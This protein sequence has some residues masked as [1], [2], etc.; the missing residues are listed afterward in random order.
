MK[1]V[2][3]DNILCIESD[4]RDRIREIYEFLSD[5]DTGWVLDFNTITNSFG[6]GDENWNRDH[7]GTPSNAI[8]V[9][10]L[11]D[12]IYEPYRIEYQFKTYETP[13][14][15]AIDKLA[16]FYSDVRIDFNGKNISIGKV[17]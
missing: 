10:H 5:R 7:W 13:P 1:D 14:D 4:D 3:V 16:E 9:S 12:D 6:Y 11:Y 15:L 2:L 17:S 8:D